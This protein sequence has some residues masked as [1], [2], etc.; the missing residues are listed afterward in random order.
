[1]PDAKKNDIGRIWEGI[2]GGITCW[3]LPWIRWMAGPTTL[4]LPA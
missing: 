1:M 3:S 2:D 4:N